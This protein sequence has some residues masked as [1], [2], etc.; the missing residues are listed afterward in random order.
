MRPWVLVGFGV[1][2]FAG[3]ASAQ[4]AW[5]EI[6]TLSGR[7][8]ALA[9]APGGGV[10]V[11]LADGSVRH[12]E[13][14]ASGNVSSDE[15]VP[16][17]T[18]AASSFEFGPAIAVLDGVVHVAFA[19]DVGSSLLSGH[20]VGK[21]ASGW[22][23]V[24]DLQSPVERGY[25]PSVTADTVG[26]AHVLFGQ[27]TNVPFG[28]A[29][30]YRVSGSVVTQSHPALI[31]WRADDRT[32]IVAGP[33]DAIHA[34]AGYP[35]PNGQINIAY[36]SNA[37][38]SFSAA[39]EIQPAD[40]GT[41]RVGQP[42]AFA[43]ASGTVHLVYGAGEEA[44]DCADCA[45]HYASIAAGSVQQTSVVTP[46]GVLDPWHLSLGIARIGV[47]SDG[48]R[49]VTWQ[50]HA[51]DDTSA[52]VSS[53]TSADGQS[54]S[55]PQAVVGDC[56]GSEGRNTID[57]S[58]ADST[59]WLA[60]PK[61]SD[62]RIFRGV[63]SGGSGC[64]PKNPFSG[65]SVTPASGSG[66]EQTFVARYSHCEGASAFR[67]VQLRVTN[68]VD[69]GEPALAL[70]FEGGLL[71]LDGQTCA[72]GEAKQLT[73]TYG[74]LDCATSSVSL[75]GNEITITFALA[76][77]VFEFAGER[78]LFVD[79]KGGS[80]APEPRL[81]WTQMGSWV[82]QATGTGSGGSGG[83]SGNSGGP[84]DRGG[85]VEDSGC[86]CRTG[87]RSAGSLALIAI[88]SLLA[89]VRRRRREQ[90]GPTRRRPWARAVRTRL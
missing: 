36:S 57:L 66:P 26:V 15:L 75:N 53:S 56:G 76:F 51:G 38:T 7:N 1:F 74:T 20:Y 27:A 64:D 44:A 37:G 58:A 9:A 41:L 35:S 59:V 65:V 85:V 19:R 82:V 32:T 90:N 48:T 55:V 54:W 71:D 39:A 42:H 23:S 5:S 8:P 46:P 22:S 33:G 40:V 72:P 63:V 45:V 67:V 34:F 60:C 13:L 52:A 87:S 70:G 11:V 83:A 31:E 69:P 6:T 81:G 88:A 79:A 49:V 12:V 73:S 89:G 29:N 84:D 78:G 25:A 50:A 17:T 16:D 18:G 43:D 80:A 68:V 77:D 62:T 30:Y 47:L 2:L 24:L 4:L 14:D 61:G 28:V 86:G 21:N 10:H 3:E